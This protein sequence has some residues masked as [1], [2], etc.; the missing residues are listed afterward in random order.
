[1]KI[2]SDRKKKLKKNEVEKQI[3]LNKKN[4]DQI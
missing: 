4:K 3:I 1:M 2:K